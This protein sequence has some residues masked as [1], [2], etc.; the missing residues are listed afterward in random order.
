M[1]HSPK[2]NHT[3]KPRVYRDFERR[4]P[5]DCRQIRP[6]GRTNSAG[7]DRQM[8][9]TKM[10]EKGQT[11]KNSVRAYVFRFAPQTRTSLGAFGMSQRCQE[12]TWQLNQFARF[13][14]TS[15][16]SPAVG[17]TVSVSCSPAIAT[18]R[19]WSVPF[20]FGKELPS[21]RIAMLLSASLIEY[22]PK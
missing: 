10:S 20:Q 13:Q 3:T 14:I 12:L 22:V 9:I 16:I 19:F 17:R 7:R 6:A 1:A 11:E 18:K 8:L 5:Q 4:P 2:G 15:T 21:T